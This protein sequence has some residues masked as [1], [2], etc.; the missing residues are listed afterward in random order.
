MVFHKKIVNKLSLQP[1]G[2]LQ[3]ILCQFS[4]VMLCE[5]SCEINTLYPC[6]STRG[7]SIWLLSL[8]C[9]VGLRLSEKHMPC[10][11]LDARLRAM[12]CCKEGRPKPMLQIDLVRKDTDWYLWTRYQD[13]GLVQDR[14]CSG[15]LSVT[16]V[17][18]VHQ[19]RAFAQSLPNCWSHCP[20]H[21]CTASHQWENCAEPPTCIRPRRPCVR[22]LLL[23][24]HRMATMV[25]KPSEME[26]Y[27]VGSY[28]L[29]QCIAFLS[30]CLW[31]TTKGPSSYWGTLLGRL[32]FPTTSLQWWQCHGMGLG[33]GGITAHG[34]TCH[35]S[36]V[37]LDGNF[38]GQQYRDE[39]LRQHVL[40]FV[41]GQARIRT[42][43]QDN[44]RPH[45]ARIFRDFL[46]CQ[47]TQVM[48]W[49][50]ISPDLLLLEHVWDVMDRCLRQV[51]TRLTDYWESS[52][53][54]VAGHRIGLLGKLGGVYPKAMCF[55]H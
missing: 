46:R 47:I 9:S 21:T 51:A 33:V 37:I 40:L 11:T 27:R 30:W 29:D 13:T 26:T 55:L 7:C 4:L 19:G 23:L 48:E 53:W 28:T 39:V 14:L 38:N 5:H 12:G 22:S 1:P 36:L 10:L 3:L 20:D 15:W 34:R 24:R 32:H 25:T 49:P 45:V 18:C 2:I 41:Q 42:L 44:A 54:A 8:K 52:L 16:E 50:A 35:L 43:L 17:G 6:R 31:R